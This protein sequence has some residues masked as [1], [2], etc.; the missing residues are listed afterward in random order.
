MTIA[1]VN[2]TAKYTITHT[3]KLMDLTIALPRATASKHPITPLPKLLESF[4][5]ESELTK[6][7]VNTHECTISI[8]WSRAGWEDL[9]VQNGYLPPVGSPLLIGKD[10]IEKLTNYLDS[11]FYRIA[12]IIADNKIEDGLKLAKVETDD[13]L[14]IL[15]VFVLDSIQLIADHHQLV[16]LQE[17][18]NNVLRTIISFSECVYGYPDQLSSTTI[19]NNLELQLHPDL[20]GLLFCSH[21]LEESST[22]QGPRL[23]YAPHRI[24]REITY[25]EIA[26]LY[27]TS[28]VNIRRLEIEK[29]R[30]KLKGKLRDFKPVNL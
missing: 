23:P 7:E 1:Q 25:E 29:C 22:H 2:N 20:C 30:P 26:N 27:R 5:L 28:R 10:I 18:T 11:Y 4:N 21:I 14:D 15:E 9:A 17:L 16:H 19:P 3:H 13:S 24:G 8:T 6:Q 12:K